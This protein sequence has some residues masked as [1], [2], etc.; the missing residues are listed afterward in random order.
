MKILK[1]NNTYYFF[2][3]QPRS[4]TKYWWFGVVFCSNLNW[5]VWV[6][7]SNLV[8]KY[9][10]KF[11]GREVRNIKWLYRWQWNWNS[12]TQSNSSE[13]NWKTKLKII[14]S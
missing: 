13:C 6:N 7:I 2:K 12:K 11:W 3:D 9:V 1:K 10:N 5:L 8:S 4:K 14:W